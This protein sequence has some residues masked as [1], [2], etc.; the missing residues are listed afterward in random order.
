M[1]LGSYLD[2]TSI[3]TNEILCSSYQRQSS[4]PFYFLVIVHED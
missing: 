1:Q 2:L 3:E 4:V